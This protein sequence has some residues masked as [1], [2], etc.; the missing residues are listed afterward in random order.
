M[1]L[2]IKDPLKKGKTYIAKPTEF[3]KY[4]IK[5]GQLLTNTYKNANMKTA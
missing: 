2:N 4:K 3:K 5:K 1:I